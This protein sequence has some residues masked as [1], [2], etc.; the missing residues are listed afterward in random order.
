MSLQVKRRRESMRV[1]PSS[2]TAQYQ[3][4]RDDRGCWPL[5][6][7]SVTHPQESLSAGCS[8]LLSLG[9]DGLGG[10]QRER[11]WEH[12]YTSVLCLFESNVVSG[13]IPK[14][15]KFLN[16]SDATC[17]MRAFESGIGKKCMG[18]IFDHPV[19]SEAL[20][21]GK[22]DHKDFDPTGR[23]RRHPWHRLAVNTS[24]PRA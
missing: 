14:W 9:S 20:E 11:E 3:R 15:V 17:G 7:F 4:H 22:E 10:L 16:R 19:V 23:R 24:R 1:A 2:K 6:G 8:F 13:G 18:E 12:L 21:N 5:W